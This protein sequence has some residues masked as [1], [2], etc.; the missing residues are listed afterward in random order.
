MLGIITV[1]AGCA[2]AFRCSD[3]NKIWSDEPC[4][5]EDMAATLRCHYLDKK[6]LYVKDALLTTE[7]PS[8]LYS[9]VRQ[10][11]RWNS[12]AWECSRRF[13][14]WGKKKKIALELQFLLAEGLLGSLFLLLWPVW[15]YLFPR[16]AKIG[17]LMDLGFLLLSTIIVS[18]S[19]SRSDIFMAF[20]KF[21]LMRF[22]DSG[23]FITSFFRGIFNRT[24][25]TGSWV[26]A[27][28]Y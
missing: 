21:I 18:I 8:D 20:P 10:A 3:F 5:V 9:Y 6:I 11:V 12:G 27:L 24:I 22:I 7:D 23:I 4:Q 17:L 2:T 19:H 1:S 13:K 26:S 15:F 16:A 25:S 28:R 14:I